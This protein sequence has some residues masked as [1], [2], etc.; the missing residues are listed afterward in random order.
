MSRDDDFVVRFAVGCLS[1]PQSAAFRVWSPHGKSDV[2]ASV[3][4]IAGEMKISLHGTGKCNAGLTDQFAKKERTAIEAMGDSRHQS[5]WN[6]LKP[7][8]FCVVVPLKLDIPASELRSRQGQP[9][10]ATKN[11]VWLKS[12]KQ[13]RTIIVYFAFTKQSLTD[14][15]WPSHLEGTHLLGTKLLPNGEKFWLFWQDCPTGPLEQMILSEAYIHMKRQK[16]VRFSSNTNDTPPTRCLIFKEFF[17]KDLL[18]VFDTA[19]RPQMV[20]MLY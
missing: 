14:F 7:D 4:N 1:G 9:I 17:E 12:P 20:Q 15:E 18:V 2:Y 19:L 3:R 13:G 11:V 6:R 10:K 5:R 16:M 8:G